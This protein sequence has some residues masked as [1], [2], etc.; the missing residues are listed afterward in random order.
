MT[1]TSLGLA[2]MDA[3]KKTQD[4]TPYARRESA[5]VLPHQRQKRWG[6]NSQA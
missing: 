5:H 3:T 2:M 6:T 4:A 1:N